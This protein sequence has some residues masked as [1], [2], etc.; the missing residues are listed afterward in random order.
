MQSPASVVAFLG[1][2]SEPTITGGECT[3]RFVTS[4][5]M[6]NPSGGVQSGVLAAMAECAFGPLAES[7]SGVAERQRTVELRVQPRVP[8][9]P[10]V[11]IFVRAAVTERRPGWVGAE[12]DLVDEDG[13][14]IASAWVSKVIEPVS[15]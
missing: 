12:A 5:H 7:L 6:T 13:Q 15:S 8:V 3:V 4:P 11:T 10:G 9:R 14:T 1:G 2:S